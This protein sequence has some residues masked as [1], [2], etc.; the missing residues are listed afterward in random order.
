LSPEPRG[1]QATQW[2]VVATVALVLA[3]AAGEPASAA[4]FAYISNQGS[5]T[6]SVIDT[7]TNTV[8]ATVPVGDI[9][10]AFGMFIGPEL[11]SILTLSGSGMILVA[12]S[13]LAVGM[14]R[15]AGRHPR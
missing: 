5:A 9:P 10:V 2:W 15:L 6:V 13:L 14:W 11:A 7:A 12:L 4:P 8:A 3:T 1:G